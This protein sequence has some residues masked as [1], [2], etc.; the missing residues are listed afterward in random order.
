[1]GTAPIYPD[2]TN[3]DEMQAYHDILKG[4]EMTAIMKQS[5]GFTD[6]DVAN[7]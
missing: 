4:A 5:F 2:G 3:F 6:A 7:Y 1:M